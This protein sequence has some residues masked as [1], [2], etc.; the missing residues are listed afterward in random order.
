[1]KPSEIKQKIKELDILRRNTIFELNRL[2]K[3]LI[4]IESIEILLELKNKY[5]IDYT[6]IAKKLDVSS[7]QIS[8]ILSQK[9]RVELKHYKKLK[10]MI[11][12][13]RIFN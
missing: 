2:K 10:K 3:K 5:K 8:S 6:I 9:S 4:Q 12:A 11:A 1:M 7:S 13:R